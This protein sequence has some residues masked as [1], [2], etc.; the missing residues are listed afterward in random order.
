M[1][2]EAKKIFR[3]ASM[4]LCDCMLN[5]NSMMKEIP[6]DDRANQ[7]PIEVLGLIWDIESDMID[8][9]K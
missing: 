6:S 2:I 3:K 5:K 8:K 4:N 1:Y 9:I 7:G